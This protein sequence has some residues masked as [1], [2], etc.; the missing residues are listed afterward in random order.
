MGRAPSRVPRARGLHLP[1]TLACDR[2]SV[3]IGLPYCRAGTLATGA[4]A[5]EERQ[6]LCLWASAHR[7]GRATRTLPDPTGRL[8]DAYLDLAGLRLLSL[9]ELQGEH[10][11]LQIGGDATLVDGVAQLKLPEEVNQ[12]VFA[13]DGLAW[14]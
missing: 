7:L 3:A 6:H 2:L 9:G 10:A 5:L 1:C 13:I 11:T 14:D 4:M 12:F 8:A